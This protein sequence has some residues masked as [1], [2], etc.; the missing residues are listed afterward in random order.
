MI[1]CLGKQINSQT[2]IVTLFNT[3]NFGEKDHGISK[4]S[5]K[6]FN[7]TCA[8]LLTIFYV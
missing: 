4:T 3:N 1:S 8:Y 7:L 2:L 6:E 5:I